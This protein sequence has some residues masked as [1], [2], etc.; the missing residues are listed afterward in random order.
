MPSPPVLLLSRTSL[1][2]LLAQNP[3]LINDSLLNQGELCEVC[4]EKDDEDLYIVFNALYR[5][6]VGEVF[7]QGSENMIDDFDLNPMSMYSN[8]RREEEFK[9]NQEKLQ[10]FRSKVSTQ[11]LL[12]LISSPRFDLLLREIFKSKYNR[13]QDTNCKHKELAM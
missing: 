2:L 4:F 8:Q 1:N 13:V 9:A 10:L 11:T 5:V 12:E 7:Q 6:A 3:A